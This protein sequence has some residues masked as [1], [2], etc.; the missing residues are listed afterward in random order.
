MDIELTISKVPPDFST[1]WLPL[2]TTVRPERIGVAL[3]RTVM[4]A[5]AAYRTMEFL[6]R[7]TPWLTKMPAR[8]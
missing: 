1:P 3:C 7:G 4:P 2:P 6:T 5:L 8:Y